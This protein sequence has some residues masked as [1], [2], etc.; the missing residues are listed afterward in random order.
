M[1]G[2]AHPHWEHFPHEA[3]MGVRGFGANRE[4]AFEQAALALTSVIA[5]LGKVEA[6]AAIE[7]ECDAPD[8]ELLFV[9]WL[10]ALVYEMATRHMLF[11]RYAVHLDGTRLTATAWGE[12]LDIARHQPAVEVKGAT[13]TGLRVAQVADGHWL[14]ECIVDV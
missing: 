7:I 9:D 12:P 14:A 10:N 13:Y 3:D 1:T 4:Q 11:S 2:I 8:Q 5:D 6:H